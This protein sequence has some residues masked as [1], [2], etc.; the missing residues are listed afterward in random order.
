MSPQHQT[1]ISCWG[2]LPLVLL[3]VVSGVTAAENLQKQSQTDEIERP[4]FFSII[5]N[6]PRNLVEWTQETFTKQ[7]AP[8]LLALT[9]A[10]GVMTMTDYETWLAVKDPYDRNATFQD[11]CN[12]GEEYSKGHI[13][14]FA[15]GTLITMGVFGDRRALRTA[16]QIGEGILSSGII[17]QLLK[18]TTGRQSPFKATTRTG[19]WRLLPSQK[20]YMKNTQEFDAMPSGHLQSAAVS[21]FV[22]MNNYPEQKWMPYVIYPALGWISFGLVGTS[23]HWW[24]DLPISIALSYSFAKMITRRNHKKKDPN[25][26]EKNSS[27]PLLLPTISMEGAPILSAHWNF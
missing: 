16:Y 1:K 26:P 25:A 3:L 8:A 14:Y 9:A 19:R 13:Q 23:I 21:M 12:R 15:M 7:N 2:W 11:F 20:D 27:W 5:T 24:S 10:T 17:V 22:V 4:K 6:I 18:H